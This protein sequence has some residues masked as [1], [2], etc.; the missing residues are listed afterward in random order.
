VYCKKGA[1]WGLFE[2]SNWKCPHTCN[3]C[4][5]FTGLQRQNHPCTVCRNSQVKY[6]GKSY[7]CKTCN[8]K[9]YYIN[10][11]TQE[12]ISLSKFLF[13]NNIDFH[14]Y[15]FFYD[16]PKNYGVYDVRNNSI[17]K[18]RPSEGRYLNGS[19]GIALI[20]GSKRI[21]S[22]I[23]ELKIKDSSRCVLINKYI[24]SQELEMAANEYI[25]LNYDNKNLKDTIQFLLD[26]R[27][28]NS[29]VEL[30]KSEINSFIHE[31]KSSLNGINQGLYLVKINKDGEISLNNRSHSLPFHFTVRKKYI[32]TLFYVNLNCSFQLNIVDSLLEVGDDDLKVEQNKKINWQVHPRFRYANLIVKI[33]FDGPEIN[34]KDKDKYFYSYKPTNTLNKLLNK[35]KHKI[36][37]ED[38][39][40]KITFNKQA[41]INQIKFSYL[42]NKCRYVNDIITDNKIDYYKWYEAEL[43][44]KSLFKEI[45]SLVSLYSAYYGSLVG[46][47]IWGMLRARES[48]TAI[49][50]SNV[51]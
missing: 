25:N 42:Q 44:R 46:G 22:Q 48:L 24:A 38:E 34:Y 20:K 45:T 11:K 16:S 50:G 2:S 6:C 27:Y 13:D 21:E 8:G 15:Y 40:H 19:I 30:A 18:Y 37:N 17:Y 39:S 43:K 47:V 14:N 5:Y 9:G 29:V 1:S 41:S 12:P 23:N 26:K 51:N 28:E 36:I 33:K 31:N 35:K 49:D 3:A 4:D 10:E 32:N 7:I